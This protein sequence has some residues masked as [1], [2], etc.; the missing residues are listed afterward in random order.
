VDESI[1]KEE[2]NA[3]NLQTFANVLNHYNKYES[4]ELLDEALF[5]AL[6]AIAMN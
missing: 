3:E 6:E 2:W 1:S 4:E 5:S